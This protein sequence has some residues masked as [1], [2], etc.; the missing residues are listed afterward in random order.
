[1]GS[2]RERLTGKSGVISA[3]ASHG[4]R[5]KAVV[6]RG[7]G[8]FSDVHRPPA[9][10]ASPTWAQ[11]ANPVPLLL[12]YEPIPWFENPLDLRDPEARGMASLKQRCN[13]PAFASQNIVGSLTNSNRSGRLGGIYSPFIS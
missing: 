10:V 12:L 9:A 13:R 6:L 7:Q 3:E 4:A 8:I 11:A 1:V 2:G 5:L